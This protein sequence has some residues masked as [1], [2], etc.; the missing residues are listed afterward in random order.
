MKTTSFSGVV[1]VFHYALHAF[2]SHQNFT[3]QEKTPNNI[4][5]KEKTIR[6]FA[7]NSKSHY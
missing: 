7:Q 1:F 3:Y 5:N 6:T 2:N 4:W